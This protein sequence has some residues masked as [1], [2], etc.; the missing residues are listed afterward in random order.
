MIDEVSSRGKHRL[1]T[2]AVTDDH[3][4]RRMLQDYDDIKNVSNQFLAMTKD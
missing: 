4:N 3:I 2:F 1:L